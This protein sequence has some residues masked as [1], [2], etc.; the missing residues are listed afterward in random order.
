VAVAEDA[1]AYKKATSAGE[2]FDPSTLCTAPDTFKT[3][4]PFKFSPDSRIYS[5]PSDTNAAAYCVAVPQGARAVEI[6]GKSKGGLTYYDAV[7]IHP[8]ILFLDSEYKT[9]ADLQRPK[10]AA[11]D[12]FTGLAVSGVVPL[13]GN[14]APA[15]FAVIYIHPLSTNDGINIFTP[16]KT[17]PVPNGPYGKVKVRFFK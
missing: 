14:L 17:I 1:E 6:H 12:G 10:L 15:K 11:E 4:V 16:Y 13:I 2:K 5:L 8:S 3:W 9:V 7:A